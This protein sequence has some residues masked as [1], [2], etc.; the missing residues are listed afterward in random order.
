[1]PLKSASIAAAT[2]AIIAW[3]ASTGAAQQNKLRKPDEQLPPA[4]ARSVAENCPG[5][6]IDKL[7]VENE[8]GVN[9]YDIEF[10]ANRGEIEVAED[11]T[12]IDIASIVKLKDI[13]KPAAD[14]ILKG[15]SGA[16]ITQ[17]EKSEVRAE[18]KAGKVV[19]LASPK[20]IYEAELAKDSQIAEIQVTSEGHVV[21]RPKWKSRSTKAK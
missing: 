8:Q 10:K 3:T 7:E 9:L 2:I 15:A 19:A 12:V 18:V 14:A 6:R 11:G 21:E 4:V 13:P 17:L 16:K 1:M 5:A 20:Y